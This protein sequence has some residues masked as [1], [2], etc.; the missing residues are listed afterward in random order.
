MTAPA[1]V[2]GVGNEYRRDDGVGAAV[3]RRLHRCTLPQVTLAI[4]D[5]ESSRLIELWGDADVAVVVDALHADG[6]E[7]GRI[8]RVVVD[9]PLTGHRPLASSH[10]MGM[11]EA[12]DLA[13]A[14]DRMPR[15]LV[16]L[17]VEGADFS[18]G[19]GLTPAVRAALDRIAALTIDELSAVASAV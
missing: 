18:V 15:R 6:G 4:T 16:I 7:P 2:I 8:H 3:V 11:G 19:R 17:A 13:L 5:G 1:V 14:L 12:V 9:R 10:G